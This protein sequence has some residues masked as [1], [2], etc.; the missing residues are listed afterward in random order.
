MIHIGCYH[1]GFLYLKEHVIVVCY[2]IFIVQVDAWN[3][4]VYIYITFLQASIK[5]ALV[6]LR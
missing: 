3:I 5:A 6:I 4:Y 2:Y 1:N